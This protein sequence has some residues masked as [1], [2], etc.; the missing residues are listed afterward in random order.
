[1]MYSYERNRC[2]A[3]QTL[4]NRLAVDRPDSPVEPT[5]NQPTVSVDCPTAVR[6]PRK[7]LGNIHNERSKLFF[8]FFSVE[9]YESLPP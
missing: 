9:S 7:S 8:A 1:M 2:P 6:Q 4:K 3:L 5:A